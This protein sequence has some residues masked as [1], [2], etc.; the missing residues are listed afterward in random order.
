MFLINPYILQTSG[1]SYSYLLDDYPGAYVAYSTRK[2]SSTYIGSCIRI[3][4]SSDNAEQDIDFVGNDLDTASISSF[5][6]AG[7]GYVV[8]W[9]DQ[10]GNAEDK[11]NSTAAN[12]PIIYNNGMITRNGKPYISASSSQWLQLTSAQNV[13]GS[14]TFFI[15]YEKDASGNQA[16]LLDGSN[17][18]AWLDYGLNQYHST[19]F[20]VPISS[21]YNVNT[22]YLNNTISLPASSSIYRNNTLIGTAGTKSGSSY[23]NRLP[24]NA[25]RSATIHFSEFIFYPSDKTSDSPDIN[26]NINNYFSIY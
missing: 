3:R 14:F 26:N 22:L 11:S 18:Y 17:T 5:C 2:L 15:T 21:V 23:L 24:G 10:S 1:G 7:V 13:S 8:K 9:Y 19:N 16:I 20:T 6:G 12:Q 25:S 4:R